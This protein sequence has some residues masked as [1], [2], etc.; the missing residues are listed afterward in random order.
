MR[1]EK[2]AVTKVGISVEGGLKTDPL[3]HRQ[4]MNRGYGEE[5]ASIREAI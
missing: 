2:D 4:R 5:P 3:T 1:G